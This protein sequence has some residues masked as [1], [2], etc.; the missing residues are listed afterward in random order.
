MGGVNMG[1][2]FYNASGQ[3]LSSV[4]DKTAT[5]AEMEAGS[6]TTAYVTPGRTQYHPGVAKAWASIT[7]AGALED[8]DY[9]IA[10]VTDSGTGDRSIVFSTAF[11]SAVYSVVSSVTNGTVQ[12]FVNN[13]DELA[14]GTCRVL[15]EN[16]SATRV[17]QATCHA[18][19]G[20]Q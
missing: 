5:Q 20:D 17:D 14:T 15:V 8:P 2:Q 9:G 13:N 6:S 1:W 3:R 16:A 4:A 18:F 19:H 12:A 10:S 11:S 7:T